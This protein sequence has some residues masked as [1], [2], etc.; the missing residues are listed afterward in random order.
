MPGTRSPKDGAAK[1]W[2]NTIPKFNLVGTA[3]QSPLRVKRRLPLTFFETGKIFT[4]KQ[5]EKSCASA[6]HKHD[7]YVVF[8]RGREAHIPIIC[9]DAS[10][11]EA[12]ACKKCSQRSARRGVGSKLFPHKA[13]KAGRRPCGYC[14]QQPYVDRQ[15]HVYLPHASVS[16]PV[17]ARHSLISQRAFSYQQ[18]SRLCS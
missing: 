5:P 13:N 10:H 4:Q 8:Q 1:A 3:Q 2:I 15:K 9:A 7:D 16:S 12:H 17:F 11:Q 18:S 14:G 6:S